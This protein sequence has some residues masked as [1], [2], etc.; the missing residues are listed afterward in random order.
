MANDN[1]TAEVIET[2]E[3]TNLSEKYKVYGVPK[4][5]MN[6]NGEVVGAVP[7]SIFL[8]KAMESYNS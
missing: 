5:I 8:N 1:I 2:Q 6:D 3:F 7:E 4:T